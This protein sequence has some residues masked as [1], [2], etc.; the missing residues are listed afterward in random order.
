MQALQKLVF[1][2]LPEMQTGAYEKLKNKIIRNWKLYEEPKF[3]DAGKLIKK[4][5]PERKNSNQVENSSDDD[6][7][8][9]Q[10]AQTEV[11]VLL[12]MDLPEGCL[13][14]NLGIPIVVVIQKA[15]VL[16]HGDKR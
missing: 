4:L 1:K 2:M 7:E 15:D 12:S 3:D 14:V 8:L 9:E 5:L 11:D 16:L 6:D 10:Q 13:R